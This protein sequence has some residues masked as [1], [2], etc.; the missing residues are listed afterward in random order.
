MLTAGPGCCSARRFG[1]WI[2]AVGGNQSPPAIVGVPVDRVKIILFIISACTA[3]LLRHH[4]GAGPSVRPIRCAALQKEFEAII[5]VGDRRHAA[6]RRLRLGDRRHVRRADLRHGQTGI[7]YTGV[8]TDWFQLFL[9][10]MLIVAVL[11][12][13]FIRR[14][15]PSHSPP[16]T[17]RRP[18]SSSDDVDKRFGST[19]ALKD[20]SFD[21]CSLAR[22]I[23][24]SATTGQ[25]NRR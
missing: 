5:A 9:G 7:F 8:D 16:M 11:F 18:F 24:C 23:A 2:F 12:N 10:A 17:K 6:H 20:V 19:I 22:S 25:A 4:S 1:N 14:R 21:A 3:T 13:D 15:D